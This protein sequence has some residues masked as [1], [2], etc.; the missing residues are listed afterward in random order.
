MEA[1]VA[2]PHLVKTLEV[3]ALS[4]LTR[5]VLDGA[6]LF[7]LGRCMCL[8]DKRALRGTSHTFASLMQPFLERT[9]SVCLCGGKYPGFVSLGI[10]QCWDARNASWS[11]LPA[12]SEGRQGGAG[13]A[14][15]NSVYICG[16]YNSSGGLRTVER[17][18]VR[19]R[20]WE[21]A[22]PLLIE[23]VAAAAVAVCGYVYVCGGMNPVTPAVE[24]FRPGSGAWEAAPAM[25][26]SRGGA[27][28]VASSGLLYVCGGFC[29]SGAGR[30]NLSSV[31]RLHPEANQWEAAPPMS[32]PRFRAAAVT[33]DGLLYLC[34]GET[35]TGYTNSVEFF[36]PVGA[37]WS[38]GPSLTVRRFGASASSIGG[39]IYVGGGSLMVSSIGSGLQ[40]V[41]RLD[42]NSRQG[43]LRWEALPDIWTQTREATAVAVRM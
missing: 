15:E 35:L 31:E 22:P 12:M 36:N 24:R 27:A 33:I 39:C 1:L 25:L 41:E 34:G 8:V 13:V 5:I 4:V 19:T 2:W 43:D 11:S 9:S 16:G 28:A 20:A 32:E 29:E 7:S 37:T 26:Q 40:T 42:V 30:Q 10:V 21:A 3:S 17:F 6:Q 18:D 14:L 23:R 38:Y